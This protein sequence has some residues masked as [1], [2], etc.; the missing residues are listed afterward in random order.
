[1]RATPQ[2]EIVESRIWRGR[3]EIVSRVNWTHIAR[4]RCSLGLAGELGSFATVGQFAVGP[5][6]SYTALRRWRGAGTRAA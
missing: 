4:V 5:R 1:M 3:V 2:D 6:A